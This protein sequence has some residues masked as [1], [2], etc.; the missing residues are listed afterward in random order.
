MAAAIAAATLRPAYGGETI[1]G[2]GKAIDGDTFKIGEAVIRLADIDAPE[3]AQ[4][5]EGGPKHLSRCGVYVADLLRSR[6][7]EKEV[8]CDVREI[9]QYDRRIARCSQGE[10]ELSAWLVRNGWALAYRTYSDRLT[11]A[12][13]E[14]RKQH[15]GLWQTSFE[16]PWAYRAQRWDVAA[17]QA[18]GGCPIKGNIARDGE[19][20]YH[21]P[22]GSQWYSRTK[23]SLNKGERWFC[24]EREALDA[25]WRAPLR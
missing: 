21:T 2:L 17:Q 14:A 10:E 23:I 9:D 22:W 3:V 4:R 25:G 11:R 7:A 18:P 13:D 12:E 8:S 24:S 20:I 19:Q 6:L 16:A 15:L 5:C 1:A